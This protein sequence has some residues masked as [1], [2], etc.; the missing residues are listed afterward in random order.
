MLRRLHN[1]H[2]VREAPWPHGGFP[3]VEERLLA[4]GGTM[5][6]Q[7]QPRTEGV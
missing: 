4:V 5:L 2:Y 1:G 6:L 3:A 7:R